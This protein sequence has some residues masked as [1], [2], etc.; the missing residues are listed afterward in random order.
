MDSQQSVYYFQDVSFLLYNWQCVS[1]WNDTRQ[2]RKG[3]Q[4]KVIISCWQFGKFPELF[5]STGFWFTIY[6]LSFCFVYLNIPFQVEKHVCVCVHTHT[7][8]HTHTYSLC[9][10]TLFPYCLTKSNSVCSTA[11]FQMIL[12]KLTHKAS[13]FTRTYLQISL[14]LYPFQ[15]IFTLFSISLDLATGHWLRKGHLHHKDES[16]SV[17]SLSPGL[18]LAK[19]N[20]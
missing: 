9:M 13:V 16:K 12:Q 14:F 7:C 2:S 18:L 10:H 17:R 19:R 11:E 4:E 8:T 5:T 3:R 20:C 15:Q 1:Q 6:N